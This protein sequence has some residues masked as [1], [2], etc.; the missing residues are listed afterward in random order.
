M[1]LTAPCQTISL[2]GK[3]LAPSLRVQ[4]APHT[5]NV[6]Q[7]AAEHD[8]QRCLRAKRATRLP[9]PIVDPFGIAKDD[10]ERLMDAHKIG[11]PR[12]LVPPKGSQPASFP[13]A[14]GAWR[15]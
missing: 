3:C 8:L 12:L 9:D 13:P 6:G 1:I 11:Q 10:S 7:L 5:H 15:R 4:V 2:C 14:K